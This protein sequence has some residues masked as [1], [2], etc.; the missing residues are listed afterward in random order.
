MVE[1]DTLADDQHLRD[2]NLLDLILTY[3]TIAKHIVKQQALPKVSLSSMHC[4]TGACKQ[5]LG[6]LAPYTG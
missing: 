5:V 4:I 3:D 2:L 6:L 1:E